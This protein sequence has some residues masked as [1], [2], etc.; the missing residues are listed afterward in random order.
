M[1]IPK[2][3]AGKFAGVPRLRVAKPGYDVTDPARRDEELSFDSAWP[4]I[5]SV[6]DASWLLDA[7]ADAEQWYADGG[8]LYTRHFKTVQF[9]ALPWEPICIG[10]GTGTNGSGQRVYVQ[11][12]CC[13]YV[14]HCTFT[15]AT[16]VDDVAYIIFANPLVA[17]DSRE[18]D[19]GGSYNILI[20]KH[21]T[22]GPGL[23]VP[24]RGADVLSCPDVD[25]RLTI[26]RPP[27]QIAEAGAFWGVP[28]SGSITKT[29]T[30]Q[31]SYPDFPPVILLANENR[32]SAPSFNGPS[33]T[34]IDS[35]TIGVYVPSNVAQAVQYIIP[36]YDPA[37]VHG[38]DE[39]STP[40]VRCDSARGL[41]ISKKNVN[42]D[43]AS[44]ANLLFD[45]TRSALHV[46]ERQAA[47]SPGI[48]QTANIALAATCAGPPLGVFGAYKYGRWWCTWGGIDMEDAA[49]ATPSTLPAAGSI[50]YQ[51]QAWINSDK[52]LKAIWQAGHVTP[53]LRV[54]VVDHSA[55]FARAVD[56]YTG[57]ALQAES[58]YNDFSGTTVGAAPAGW[59]M[60]YQA[61]TGCSLLIDGVASALNAK[62]LRVY[63][64]NATETAEPTESTFDA[65]GGA[66]GDCDIL[67]G[68]M[69]VNGP[70]VWPAE[71]MFVRSAVGVHQSAGL[72]CD[73]VSGAA[74]N[75][76]MWFGPTY[77]NP[78]STRD[79]DW[80]YDT[81][82]WLRLN[83]KGDQ[84]R[85]KV[86]PRGTPE[87]E[88]WALAFVGPGAASG[89][90]GLS[91]WPDPT[92]RSYMDFISVCTTGRPAWGPLT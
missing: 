54:G 37:Y 52:R 50:N 59:T 64:N 85:M 65:P 86:W 66:V 76:R 55:L 74:A 67:T 80:A 91:Q 83:V 53:N 73:V 60:R 42:V 48:A 81:W 56:L 21:P 7:P 46:S 9:P 6:L 51:L 23:F 18:T 88:P 4:E 16:A 22:R 62:A 8:V 47:N 14:D 3:V 13:S 36:A 32:I 10:W 35:S 75:K 41:A 63:R 38:P 1:L 20:G 5:L 43:T 70:I 24:R 2:V 89:Y 61:V 69:L 44:A 29:V 45:A 11:N 71:L 79:F 19:N 33:V 17:A 57:P 26:E 84:R 39:V 27:L 30:L 15:M 92:A 58:T 40:R 72:V 82:Y 34:W 90:I 87:P 31:G 25:L 49:V 77:D 78:I 12:V 68:M 28:S